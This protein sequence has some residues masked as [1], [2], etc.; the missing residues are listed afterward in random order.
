M[1]R[2]PMLLSYLAHSGPLTKFGDLFSSVA[3]LCLLAALLGYVW[4]IAAVDL[5]AA[6]Y[7][8]RSPQLWMLV[9]YVFFAVGVSGSIY[10]IIRSAPLYG[11]GPGGG[12][13][14]F[15]SGDREQYLLEGLVVATFILGTALA[16]VLLFY[17]VKIRFAFVRH[18]AVIM[19]MSVFAVMLL[20]I[21]KMYTEKTAWYSLKET[22]PQISSSFLFSS[23]KKSSW[24]PKRLLR[25][26]E[27]W[28]NDFH[29]TEG[30]WDKFKKK[31]A[32]LIVDYI[33]RSTGY[34]TETT[35]KS[36]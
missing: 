35:A 17:S 22:L 15:S 28:L 8:Y 18:C 24:L 20:Q 11:A 23:V 2:I 34:S 32:S 26:S 4:S 29:F 3:L 14:I 19:S 25:L 16:G 7:W 1:I 9:S 5:E 31:F 13:E 6:L 12:I 36:S 33:M 10:C 27:I 21:W 30:D